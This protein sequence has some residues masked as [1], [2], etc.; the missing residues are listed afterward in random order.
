MWLYVLND[1]CHVSINVVAHSMELCTLQTIF[2]MTQSLSTRLIGWYVF[3]FDRCII[4][5]FLN[6]LSLWKFSRMHPLLSTRI[7]LYGLFRICIDRCERDKLIAMHR[8]PIPRIDDL[9][10]SS[11]PMASSNCVFI[12]PYKDSRDIQPIRL[13]PLHIVD[14]LTFIDSVF[15]GNFDN[16][17]SVSSP[18]HH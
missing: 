5:N 2:I 15:V 10:N 16:D 18:L 6:W 11:F 4:D 9:L 7:S 1:E 3:W 17:L 14:A 13:C 8:E 12:F